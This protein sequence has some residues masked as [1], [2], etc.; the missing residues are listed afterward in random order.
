MLD[1]IAPFFIVRDVRAAA[2]FYCEK[3]G[4]GL[5]LTV[6]EGEPFFGIVRRDA[7]QILLKEIS[8]EV[9][10]LPNRERHPWARWDAFVHTS[11]AEAVAAEFI[12][13]GVGLHRALSRTDD[14]LYGF[15]V[16]GTDGYVLFSGSPRG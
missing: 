7:V 3:L 10:P 4:F 8:P 11:Q 6:P 1:S 2:A 12:A 15:E 14:G 13:R 9:G 5:A 16:Q